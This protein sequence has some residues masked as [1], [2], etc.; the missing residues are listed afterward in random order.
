MT[1]GAIEIAREQVAALVSAHPSQVI[2]T[3]GGTEANNLAIKGIA[4]NKKAGI[5]S[6]GATEH[7]SVSNPAL[8]LTTLGWKIRTI[9]V[10]YSGQIDQTQLISEPNGSFQL[11]SL[12]LANNET[13]VIQDI[14]Q[15]TDAIKSDATI[16]HTDAIQAAGKIPINFERL[17]VHL[18]SLSAHKIYG[19]KGIGALIFDKS[20]TL[21]PHIHGG[22][23]EHELRGG[24]E[25]VAAI[26]G[27]G[28]AAEL[29]INELENRQQHFAKHR[30]YLEEALEKYPGIT[31]FGKQ[32]NRLSNTLLIGIDNTNGEMLLMELDRKGIAISSG[33]ACSSESG[34][35]SHVLMA[36]G[37]NENLARSAIR[38]SLGIDNTKADI[39]QFL[40]VLRDL[41]PSQ[42]L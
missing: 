31:I 42:S 29:A 33:S 4:S 22:G 18:M 32:T 19:P 3:S 15:L 5:I 11:I 26:V 36:M 28:K 37:V 14:P 20:V 35:P 41:F 40:I 24:T 13:G 38:I 25:N 2:F 34:K 23:Q 16:I 21:E 39:D 8:A 17:G 30:V 7:P 9:P 27:F 12:M 1:R 6:I 10:N